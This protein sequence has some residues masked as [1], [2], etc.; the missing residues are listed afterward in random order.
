MGLVLCSLLVGTPFLAITSI[1]MREVRRL[2]G[3]HATKL[4]GLMTASYATGQIAGP[5]VATT[6]TGQTHGFGASLGIAATALLVGAL[7]CI[8]LMSTTSL[9]DRTA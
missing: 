4:I 8:V 6:L 1:A 7:G 9:P 2:R 3:T 5:L